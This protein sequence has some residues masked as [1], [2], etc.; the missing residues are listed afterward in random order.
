MLLACCSGCSSPWRFQ[1]FY[2][3]LLHENATLLLWTFAKLRK[4]TISFV[5]SL[6]VY[7]YAWNNSDPT[8]RIFMKFYI[9]PF[10][11]YFWEYS[12]MA[13]QLGISHW[14]LCTFMIT[15]HWILLRLKTFWDKKSRGK[16]THGF[17]NNDFFF[18]KIV[19]FRRCEENCGRNTKATG[20]N[21][22]RHVRFVCWIAKAID[23]HTRDMYYLLLFHVNNGYSKTSLCYVIRKFQVLL[24]PT[25]YP[26][27][28]KLCSNVLDW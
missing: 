11:E 15:Y 21:L 17:F 19:P 4:A 12:N 13:K 27:Y 14:D 5:M 22:T 23:T 2:A 25:P 16:Q 6:S 18:P 28:I 8:G 24:A 10:F 9:C 7:S 26:L 3:S 1:Q 20:G